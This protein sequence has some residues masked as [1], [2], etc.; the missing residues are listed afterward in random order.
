MRRINW[1]RVMPLGRGTSLSHV[2]L[3]FEAQFLWSLPIVFRDEQDV[4]LLTNSGG[5]TCSAS[6]SSTQKS[7]GATG[8]VW[9]QLDVN[10]PDTGMRYVNHATPSPF[11][12]YKAPSPPT[13]KSRMCTGFR[14]LFDV[15]TLPYS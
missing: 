13:P 12:S 8:C 3:L 7:E 11:V 15:C 10:T 6:T 9:N 14:A 5:N 2:P 4:Q 1:D